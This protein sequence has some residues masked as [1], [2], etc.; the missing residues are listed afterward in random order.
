[1]AIGKSI[2][3]FSIDDV[4]EGCNYSDDITAV[5]KNQSPDSLN[6]EFFNGRIKKRPGETSFT[7]PPISNS[8]TLTILAVA[9][10]GGAGSGNASYIGG[11]GG[12]GAGELYSGT[13]PVSL[14]SSTAVTVGAG[15]A[16]VPSDSPGA[17]GGDSI[18]ATI[19]V[20]GGGGGGQPGNANGG[21]GGCGGGATSDDATVQTGGTAQAGGFAGGGA[22]SGGAGFRVGGGGGGAGAVGG[23]GVATIGLAAT[24]GNGGN[25][26]ANSI[27]GASVTYAGG[28]GGSA[29]PNATPPV[30]GTG[31]TG[32]GGAGSHT[33]AG[34][35]GT[36]NTGSGGGAGSPA[37]VGGSGIV[38]VS[39]ATPALDNGT[40]G[41]ITHSGGNTIHTFTSSGTFMAPTV[42]ATTYTGYSLIDYSD[43]QDRH[44]QVAHI[45]N[46]VYAYDRLTS[47]SD[48]IRTS[49][50][51]VRSF[52]A[53][54]GAY[55]IQTYSDYSAPYYWDG[56]SATMAVVSSNAPGFKRSIEFQGYLIG[57][58]TATATTRCYYQPIGN[59][60]GGGAAYTDYFTLTPAPND[61]E[62][63]DPFILNGRLYIGTKY[64]IFRVSFVGGVTVF[65]FK[66]VISDVGIVPCTSQTVITKQFGQVVLFLGTDKRIYMFDGANVKTIS[67]LYYYRNRSTPIALDMIDDTYKENSF[68]VYDITRR[69]Y[70]LVITKNAQT[71]NEYCMNIDVDTLAYYPFDNMSFSCGAVCYDTLLRP[72]VVFCD[73]SGSLHKMFIDTP[74]DNGTAINE[75]YKSPLVSSKDT[76]TKK[77]EVISL[78]MLPVSDANLNVYDKVDYCRDW[79][80]RQKV[81]LCSSRDKTLGHSFVLNSS[82]LGSEKELLH[83]QI[84]PRNEFNTYQ[85]KLVSDTPTA[86]PWE[87]QQIS[88]NQSMLKF[89]KAEA[90]R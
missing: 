17:S 53:K 52:N 23:D 7:T 66:Q 18:F 62:T 15:S 38:I 12:G 75:Y 45:G 69:I 57:M 65:E 11:T 84:S 88:V 9:G 30:D 46:A 47:T 54:I 19:T 56:S 68:A 33:G 90:Q 55:L 89:G 67:D 64:G 58:N 6:V 59:I 4:S 37:G 14:G 42:T 35:D 24:G 41:T 32:G 63:T 10:G 27:S 5:K 77:G 72:F 82:L 8:L 86:A 21:N 28:G 36:V 79:Q 34:T 73:Y 74:T 83:T 61:D 16:S 1:M 39:Y 76:T 43:V 20:R 48:T 25:G 3:T 87:I 44:R 80:F 71:T 51:Q 49:V 40:G 81:P 85:F 26:L 13:L 31:G 2:T 70:R 29:D 78:Q 60:L 50:P 22:T